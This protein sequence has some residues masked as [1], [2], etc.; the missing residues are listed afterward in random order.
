MLSN[1]TYLIIYILL[2]IILSFSF[3]GGSINSVVNQANRPSFYP[4][5]YLIGLVWFILFILFGIFLYTASDESYQ[6]LGLLFYTLTLLWTPLFVYSKSF[7]VG[8]YYIL[9]IWFLTIAFLVYTKS[10]LLLGQ[11]IWITF[12]T[13]L[14]YS[15]YK[16]N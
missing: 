9:F 12:A 16:I 15:L 8:F 11:M 2:L 6:Y 13:I 14:A 3:S 5:G 10:L 1:T 7:A 4:P